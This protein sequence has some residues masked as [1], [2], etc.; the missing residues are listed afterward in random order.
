[1]S[2]FFSFFFLRERTFNISKTKNPC[3]THYTLFEIFTIQK[4]F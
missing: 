4:T 1:M 3:S 2:N